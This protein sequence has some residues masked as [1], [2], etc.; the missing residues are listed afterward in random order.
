MEAPIPYTA[1]TLIWSGKRAHVRPGIMAAVSTAPV[2]YVTNTSAF[3]LG[4]SQDKPTPLPRR[5]IRLRRASELWRPVLQCARAQFVDIPEQLP[6]VIAR[7][8]GLGS[9]R[10]ELKRRV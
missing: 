3:L 9:R 10:A 8:V 7:R 6:S 1:A 4:R 2:Q 5:S